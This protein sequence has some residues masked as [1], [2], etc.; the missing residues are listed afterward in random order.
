MIV[1][2]GLVLLFGIFFFRNTENVQTKFPEPTNEIEEW[3]YTIF[4]YKTHHSNSGATWE[5]P[6]MK[7]YRDSYC[8]VV[9]YLNETPLEFNVKI[10]SMQ[11]AT[12]YNPMY[13]S[14]DGNM[15]GN[16]E[17]DIL[18]VRTFSEEPNNKKLNYTYT[19]YGKFIGVSK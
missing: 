15:T 6:I 12:G 7:I 8:D 16:M 4:G 11:E 1:V 19:C 17:E 3:D 18:N 9:L 13:L 5:S 10:D 14:L 2:V